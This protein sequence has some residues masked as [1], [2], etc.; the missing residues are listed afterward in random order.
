MY[1][2]PTLREQDLLAE[3]LKLDPKPL[4][5]RERVAEGLIAAAFGI[6]AAV[7]FAIYP[8]GAFALLPA[9]VCVV[10][11]ALATRVH[12]HVASGFTV[13]TQLAF[14]PLVFAVPVA[15]GPLAVVL[16]LVLARLPDVLRGRARPGRLL[17][18]I[19]NSWFAIGPAA[20]FA[21]FGTDPSQAGAGLLIG[22]LAAQ[23]VADFT[24]SSVRD[25]VESKTPLRE[26]ARE[27]WVYAVD[28][29]FS[30]VGFAVAIQLEA[31]PA[32]VLSLVPMLGVLAVFA[33]E[34]E[35]RLESM[36]ELKNAYHGTAL[37]LGD[38]VEA[39][40]A[41]TGAHC[42]DV[43]QLA[44]DVGERLGLDRER[45]RHLEF[46]A[47]LHDVGK[48]AIPKEIINKPGKLDPQEW[49]IVKTHT[50]EGQ[51]MLERVGGFMGQVGLIVRSHHERWDGTGYP[52]GL[53][54][55]A[56]PVESRII[57]CCD[58]WHAM[59]TTRSYRKAMPHE[60][61]V[62]E[63]RKSAGR[64][65]DPQI[66]DALLAIVEP[67]AGAQ[68]A[69]PDRDHSRHSLEGRNPGTARAPAHEINADSVSR[70]S[71]TGLRSGRRRHAGTASVLK[72]H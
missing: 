28:A 33:R 22:A 2:N 26:Q 49:T 15:V 65:L 1:L 72:Q 5:L 45:C 20:V 19:G 54:G 6:A 42:H 23:F 52:D 34:R 11:L 61:A 18:C 7:L 50:V 56:I 25:A 8:P 36:I 70:V 62:A 60:D 16:S 71:P 40:D 38:V 51:R 43:V 68:E 17:F 29:A 21:G 64:Q 53:A 69:R 27:T 10:V 3:T 41:Y 24:A 32:V 31:A 30:P 47:L 57:S 39:D 48:I 66:V 44:L 55:E 67:S 63:L 12:F 46:G 4:D 37:L 9:A 35:A 14:V 59:R 58:T 13:P